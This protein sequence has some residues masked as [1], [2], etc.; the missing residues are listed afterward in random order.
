MLGSLV[1]TRGPTPTNNY[2]F[3]TLCYSKVPFALKIEDEISTKIKDQQR[4]NE[5]LDAVKI[6]LKKVLAELNSTSE[7][8]KSLAN[9]NTGGSVSHL[10]SS[11]LAEQKEKERRQLNIIVHNMA[12]SE[13]EDPSARKTGD[14]TEATSLFKEY[15]GV[16][17]TVT[18]A[19]RIGK[20]LLSHDYLS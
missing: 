9:D 10:A 3:C 13:D 11:I 6:K 7:L 4:A 17:P 12:E 16:E 19:V 8:H 20:K 5:R 14:I 15:L 18:N 1:Y 2:V